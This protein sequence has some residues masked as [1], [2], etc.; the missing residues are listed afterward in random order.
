MA[1]QETTEGFLECKG[2]ISEE[3][4]YEAVHEEV[5]KEEAAV[6]S[7]GALKNLRGD[8]HLE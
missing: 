8:R 2:P 6:K 1:C 7:F 4:Q 3:M 5:P